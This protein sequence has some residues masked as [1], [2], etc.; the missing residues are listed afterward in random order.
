MNRCPLFA[1]ALYLSGGALILAGL[2]HSEWFMW[3]HSELTT[4]ALW[5]HF[6]HRML[7]TACTL[8]GGMVLACLGFRLDEAG[9]RRGPRPAPNRRA[10]GSID[11]TYW[12]PPASPAPPPSR[13]TGHP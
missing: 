1:T 6:P 7:L 8:A 11:S 2:V 10:D 4:R 9:P 5:L 12:Q 13:K 3:T